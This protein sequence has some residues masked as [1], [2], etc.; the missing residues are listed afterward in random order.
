MG[1]FRAFVLTY[2]NLYRSELGGFFFVERFSSAINFSSSR[3]STFAEK[4]VKS[5]L[6][7]WGSKRLIASFGTG[8]GDGDLRGD[9]APNPAKSEA[10]NLLAW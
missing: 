6:E 10:K 5:T 9:D 3:T 4:I 1:G 7:E 2:I 8:N